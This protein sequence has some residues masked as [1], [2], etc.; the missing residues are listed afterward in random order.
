VELRSKE[1]TQPDTGR[2]CLCAT[3]GTT[4]IESAGF[5]GGNGHRRIL[6]SG[7]LRALKNL[8]QLW[9][10]VDNRNGSPSSVCAQL[11]G[12]ANQNG[13]TPNLSAGLVG[14]YANSNIAAIFCLALVGKLRTK[15]VKRDGRP[16]KT[17]QLLPTLHLDRL[18]RGGS[19]LRVE[20]AAAALDRLQIVVKLIDERNAGRDIETD[21]ILIAHLVQMFHDRA[22]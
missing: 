3:E 9:I 12:N 14:K 21:D 15:H 1:L 2:S 13:I 16:S 5:A 10:A 18:D 19:G 6:K 11:V 17:A 4:D 7:P 22:Y 8:G 20:V